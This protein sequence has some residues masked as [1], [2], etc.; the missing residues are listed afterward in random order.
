[1]RNKRNIISN[2]N[3][4]FLQD[5]TLRI[6]LIWRL[7]GDSRVNLLLKVLPVGALVYLVLP[8]DLLP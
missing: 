3:S 8:I 6:K 5:L 7:M 2:Q 1:M 4:G